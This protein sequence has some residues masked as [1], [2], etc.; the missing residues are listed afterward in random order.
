MWPAAI[1][2]EDGSPAGGIAL[3]GRTGICFSTLTILNSSLQENNPLQS[4]SIGANTK[5]VS[6]LLVP[7]ADFITTEE[8]ILSNSQTYLLDSVPMKFILFFNTQKKRQNHLT[9]KNARV[10][11]HQA[12]CLQHTVRY[13]NNCKR[14]GSFTALW[15]IKSGVWAALCESQLK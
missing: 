11:F 1:E 7:T 4:Q 13:W 15:V 3:G 2:R 5:H 6:L 10:H 14:R 9:I 8:R 12:L